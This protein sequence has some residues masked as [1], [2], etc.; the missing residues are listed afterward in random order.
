MRTAE[1]DFI[2]GPGTPA[3]LPPPRLKL[4]AVR[5]AGAARPPLDGAWWPRS[6]DPVA[7]LPGLV[8]ALQTHGPPHDQL[9]ITHVMMRAADWD[10]HPR[11]LLVDGPD[12]TRVVQ[13]SWF[14]NLPAGLLTAIY[15][16][17]R[18]LNLLTVPASTDPA[19]A[20]AA[21]EMAA[22]RADLLPAPD[23]LGA[24]TVPADPGGRLHRYPAGF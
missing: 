8:L 5:R 12:D 14:R 3:H 1:F 22:D 21:L 19:A 16:D 13:L 17:G 18:R 6:A 7:D 15:A 20:E 4:G 10:R 2:T 9:P 11:R 23:R 24:L